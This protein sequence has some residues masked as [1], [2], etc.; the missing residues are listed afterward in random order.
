MGGRG[1]SLKFP[2]A[3][4]RTDTTSSVTTL[5]TNRFISNAPFVA[6][7]FAVSSIVTMGTGALRREETDAGGI[8]IMTEELKER[9]MNLTSLRL[10]FEYKRTNLWFGN[11]VEGECECGQKARLVLTDKNPHKDRVQPKWCIACFMKLIFPTS[12]EVE[13]L[14]YLRGLRKL[15]TEYPDKCLVDLP[16]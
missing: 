12:L 16:G 7:S 5:T 9:W 13:R 3:A 4:V 14:S 2:A 1:S 15:K 11:L 8:F 10:P 6:F